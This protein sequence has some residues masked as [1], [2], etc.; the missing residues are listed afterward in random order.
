MFLWSRCASG[1][2]SHFHVYHLSHPLAG[3]Y[4]GWT[5]CNKIWCMSVDKEKTLCLHSA[6]CVLALSNRPLIA[7]AV[8]CSSC[9][10]T[11]IIGLQSYKAANKSNRNAPAPID[12]CSLNSHFTCSLSVFSVM[13]WAQREAVKSQQLLLRLNEGLGIDRH[14]GWG[15][16]NQ[17]P[18]QLI[19]AGKRYLTSGL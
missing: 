1:M 12:S 10:A 14:R 9:R 5:A 6:G 7:A 17:V 15:E 18:W 2:P 8:L 13:T 3:N 19:Q 4:S 11:S 16:P